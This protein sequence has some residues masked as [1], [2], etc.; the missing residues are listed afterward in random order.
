MKTPTPNPTYLL[1]KVIIEPT[2]ENYHAG[3]FDSGTLTGP[4]REWLKENVSQGWNWDLER[5]PERGKH[6]LVFRFRS[7]DEACAFRMV[8]F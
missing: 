5:V 6:L 1:H 7:P 3:P 8:W 4:M 2:E